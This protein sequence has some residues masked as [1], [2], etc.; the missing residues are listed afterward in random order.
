MGGVLVGHYA[1]ES[2][3]VEAD[4]AAVAAVGELVP[5]AQ[6]ILVAARVDGGQWADGVSTVRLV[7]EDHSVDAP[8][9][10]R[11]HL[12]VC[13]A[14]NHRCVRLIAVG[15]TASSRSAAAATSPAGRGRASAPIGPKVGAALL[16]V[17]ELAA[18]R[19]RQKHSLV[20]LLE[21]VLNLL[22]GVPFEAKELNLWGPPA[23][24]HRRLC[25]QQDRFFDARAAN[26]GVRVRFFCEEVKL[27]D[28]LL[29]VPLEANLLLNISCS[30]VS[31]F[32]LR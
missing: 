8:Q 21:R 31:L 30:H 17:V 5:D 18:L 22:I 20:D 1:L 26:V 7:R 9:I 4:L 16:G 32:S 19:K 12:V 13:D 29:N 24:L 2:R 6:D 3:R 25:E 14:H 10:L 23:R 15:R 11:A 27:G 28:E